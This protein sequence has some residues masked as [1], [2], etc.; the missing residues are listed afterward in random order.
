MRVSHERQAI[1]AL[2]E[3][4][5]DLPGIDVFSGMGGANRIRIEGWDPAPNKRF[6]FGDLRLESDRT[7]AVVEFESAGGATNLVKYWPLLASRQPKR[8]V[9][10][11]VFRLGSTDDYIAH[12]RL[13]AFLVDRMRADLDSV[14]C[15]DEDWVA[16][17]FTYPRD[18]IDVSE[19]A[20]W[21]TGE[22]LPRST[23]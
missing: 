7:T 15:W 5:G 6:Q 14:M 16:R 12:R 4:L 13:W 10:A 21:L 22:L 9:L 8:F 23:S 18:A 3:A 1:G 19:L 2:R 20:S 11:H 17:A